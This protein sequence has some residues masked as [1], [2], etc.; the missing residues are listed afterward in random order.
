MRKYRVA[1]AVLTAAEAVCLWITALKI[2]AVMIVMQVGAVVIFQ[3]LLYIESRGMKIYLEVPPVVKPNQKAKITVRVK[4]KR[5]CAVGSLLVVKLKITNLL[6][7]DVKTQ[8]ITVRLNKKENFAQVIF[9]SDFCA[10]TQIKCEN[11]RCC[12]FFGISTAE[13]DCDCKEEIMVSLNEIPMNVTLKNQGGAF[14]D[15]DK[16]FSQKI[17][18]DMSEIHDLREYAL[19]DDVRTIHWKLSQKVGKEIVKQFGEPQKVHAMVMFDVGLKSGGKDVDKNFIQSALEV[20]VAV[21]R[22]FAKQGI[23]HYF[24]AAKQEGIFKMAVR[25]LYDYTKAVQMVLSTPLEENMGEGLI[26]LS[27]EREMDY[28]RLV[29]VTCSEGDYFQ[30]FPKGMSVCVLIVSDCEQMKA[31]QNNGQVIIQIPNESIHQR[32]Y[33]ITV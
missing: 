2:F 8:Q 5:F 21:S 4:F 23:A 12:G 29:Y 18:R 33:D 9:E 32:K 6:F 24:A 15:S 11:A 7:M 1:F 31:V 20:S 28:S 27:M 19:G 25:N 22:E 16:A 14:E 17:G 30:N 3:I 26:K 10:K 13:V